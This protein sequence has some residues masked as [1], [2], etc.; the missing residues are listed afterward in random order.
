M[1]SIVT[2][3][4][5]PAALVVDDDA[6]VRDLLVA[7]LQ[8]AGWDVT[9]VATLAEA[10][11]ARKDRTYAL[12][13]VD[14]YLT[15]GDGRA[16]LPEIAITNGSVLVISGVGDAGDDIP[17]APNVAF[18]A[19]PFGSRDLL[20][21]VSRLQPPR[22]AFRTASLEASAFASSASTMRPLSMT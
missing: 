12:H 10:R 18:L 8:R 22:Y 1:A 14:V 21:A 9:G 7:L 19:K 5:K 17:D 13:V 3:T 6:D 4:S 11:Q 15:D 2:C 20:A 16:L